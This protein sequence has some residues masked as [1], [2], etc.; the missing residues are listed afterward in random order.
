MGLTHW[1]LLVPIALV[2]GGVAVYTWPAA[3]IVAGVGL[4]P[5]LLYRPIGEVDDADEGH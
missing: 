3:L 5:W 1:L 4:L 2:V